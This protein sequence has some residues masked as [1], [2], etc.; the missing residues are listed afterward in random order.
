MSL[1]F[2]DDVVRFLVGRGF[3]RADQSKSGAALAAEVELLAVQN[4]WKSCEHNELTGE[5][6]DDSFTRFRGQSNLV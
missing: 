6:P 4:R 3:S 2:H 5:Q 1:G